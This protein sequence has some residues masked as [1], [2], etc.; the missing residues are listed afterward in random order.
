[1][2]PDTLSVTHSIGEL[3]ACGWKILPHEPGIYWW[4]FPSSC[5]SRFQIT[6]H[7]DGQ[8]LNL[9]Q[10]NSEKV[11]LYVGVARSL[12]ERMRWH[13]EQ[14]LKQSAL[15]SGFLSTFRKT[16]LALNQI[17]YATGFEAVNEFMDGLDVAWHTMPSIEAAKESEAAELNGDYHFPLN[18]QGNKNPDLKPFVR[19]LKQRRKEY[20]KQ[21]LHELEALE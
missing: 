2:T 6:D 10:G 7:C 17:D 5:L 19:F 8:N 13:A 12:N 9:R 4:F 20:V 18:I 14:P 16:L 15:R 3:R 11:C 21:F 1:M